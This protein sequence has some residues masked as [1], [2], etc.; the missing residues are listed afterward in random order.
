MRFVCSHKHKHTRQN[1]VKPRIANNTQK[2][3]HKLPGRKPIQTRFSLK[4][5]PKLCSLSVS[6][7][8]DE[9]VNH[10]TVSETT[11]MRIKI[12]ADCMRINENELPA[13]CISYERHSIRNASS[14]TSAIHRVNTKT[15]KALPM[16]NQTASKQHKANHHSSYLHFTTLLPQ[17]PLSSNFVFLAI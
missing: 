17:K 11:I 16:T 13:R 1:V 14:S 12:A 7:C 2:R 3:Y 15:A 4:I 10:C 9:C 5:S 6:E 8:T